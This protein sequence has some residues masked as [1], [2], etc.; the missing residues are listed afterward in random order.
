MTTEGPLPDPA[1][2]LEPA[3]PG[4]LPPDPDGRLVALFDDLEQQ[5]EGLALQE[6]DAEVAELTRSAYAEVDLVSRLHGSVGH[7]VALAIR[8]VGLLS[9]QVRRAGTDFVLLEAAEVTWVVRSAALTRVGG[10]TEA[11]VPADARPLPAR[12]G[13]GS[14]LRGFAEDGVPVTVHDLDG[15]VLRG[16]VRR[17]GAD[18]AE[19]RPDGFGASPVLLPF[20]GLAAVRPAPGG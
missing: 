11:A 14:V 9:G 13:L 20:A 10:L 5:A 19:L 17:V 8:G 7:E 12:V 15:E 6:R 4:A 16:V 1:E 2:P 18:F 3:G